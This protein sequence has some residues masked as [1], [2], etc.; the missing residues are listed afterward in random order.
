M[1]GKVV[2]FTGTLQLVTR[3]EAKAQAQTMGLKVTGSVSSK[4]D[5]IVFGENAGSKLEKAKALDVTV[6]S[7]K[8]WFQLLETSN[9]N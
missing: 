6:V 4:T 8:E 3:A 7:E 1:A 9:T 5:F 2:V